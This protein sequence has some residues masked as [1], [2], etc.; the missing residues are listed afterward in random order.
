MRAEKDYEKFLKL[1]NKHKLKYCIIGAYAV[2]F[3]AKPRYTKAMDIFVEPTVDNAKK[4]LKVLKEF[5]FGELSVPLDD[6]TQEGN[7]FQLGYEPVRI[8][9][10]TKIEGFRFQEA[11][12][13]RVIGDYG[14]EKVNFIGLDDL[15]EN[16]KIS[17]RRSEK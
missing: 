12:T 1:L 17:G 4:T 5:G 2:A 11:W 13:N 9:P 8:D 6:L 7:I 14:S 3:Y 16:K 15:I 10:L